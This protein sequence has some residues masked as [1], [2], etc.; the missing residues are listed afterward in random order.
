M[1]E[2]WMGMS[3]GGHGLGRLGVGIY[4]W[5]DISAEKI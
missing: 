1:I 3:G 2:W 5:D 4:G